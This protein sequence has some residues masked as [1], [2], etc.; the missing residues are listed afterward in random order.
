MQTEI[1][2]LDANPQ[3]FRSYAPILVP[4]SILVN[5]EQ[6]SVVRVEVTEKAEIASKVAYYRKLLAKNDYETAL[7][8]ESV[9]IAAQSYIEEATKR[10]IVGKVEVGI[11]AP[12]VL[13]RSALRTIYKRQIGIVMILGLL[14][15]IALAWNVGLTLTILMGGI[16]AFYFINLLLTLY[17]SVRVFENYD[18]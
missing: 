7:R 15:V 11:Y 1:N 18:V 16:T 14:I 3:A 4:P 10:H 2:S 9:Q 5:H 12:F 8:A 6:E 13:A 17:L